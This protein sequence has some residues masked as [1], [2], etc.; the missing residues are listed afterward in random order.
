MGW[1]DEKRREKREWWDGGRGRM[2]TGER[3]GEKSSEKER[4]Q[5]VV[6]IHATCAYI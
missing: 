3:G 6:L 2:K 1:K 4:R 5:Y